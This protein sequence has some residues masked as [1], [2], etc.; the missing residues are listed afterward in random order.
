MSLPSGVVRRPPVLS[1]NPAVFGG[2]MRLAL[3]LFLVMLPF[4]V[5]VAVQVS[6]TNWGY[7]VQRKRAE[8]A[9]EKRAQQLLRAELA[10]L[11]S[12]DRLREEADR[13]GLMPAPLSN[14]P[15][16]LVRLRTGEDSP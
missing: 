1:P 16:S 3:R 2:L 4:L 7:E 9:R 5:L 14:P 11:R 8:I 15:R 10:A 13:L 12:P 6:G